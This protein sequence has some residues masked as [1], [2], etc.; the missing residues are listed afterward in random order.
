M[1]YET[2][3]NEIQALFNVAWLANAGTVV[4]GTVPP[5]LWDG[6]DAGSPPPV[7][8]PHARFFCR[9]T[10]GKQGSL[11]GIGARQFD[12]MGLVTVQVFV[13]LTISRALLLSGNLAK[14]ARDAYEGVGTASGI[15]FRNVKLREIGPDRGLYQTNVTAEFEY[16]EVK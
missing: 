6:L 11:G 1:S 3:R 5:I 15:W 12:R 9:H 13:P 4:G 2:S 14:I 16:V 8:A 7:T 10:D